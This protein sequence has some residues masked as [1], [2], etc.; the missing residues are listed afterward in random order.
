MYYQESLLT[1]LICSACDSYSPFICNCHCNFYKNVIV[2][3]KI[4]WGEG[5]KKRLREGIWGEITKMKRHLRYSME[6]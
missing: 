6:I 3:E 1:F 4:K 2:F 5:R